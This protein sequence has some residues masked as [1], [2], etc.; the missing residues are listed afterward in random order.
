MYQRGKCWISDFWHE[1]RRY[2]KSWGA[3]SKTV[4]GEKDRKFRTEVLEGKHEARSRKITFKAF[5]GKYLESCRLNLKPKFAKRREVSVKALLPHFGNKLLKEISPFMAEQFKKT[6]RETVSPATVN[7]D[8][9]CLKNTLS[10]A[11]EWG[12]LPFNSL[13][14]R[15]VR[16]F[17]EDNEKMWALSDDEEIKLLDAC[18]KSPQ[19]GAK[20]DKLFAKYLRDLV[21]VALHSGMREGEIFNLRKEKVFLRDR[22]IRV[23]D[24]KNGED[25][26]VPIND[27]LKAVL[28]NRMQDQR[29]EYLFCNSKRERLTVLSSAFWFAIREAGLTRI[30]AKTGKEVRFRFHDLRHTFGSRL[31]MAGKDLKTIM[32]IMGHKSTRVA[33]RY[34]HPAPE[35]KLEAVRSLDKTRVEVPPKVP[36]PQKDEPKVVNVLR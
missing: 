30:D 22:Y 1:G 28:E 32:E 4:A 20:R 21:T 7:R 18:E 13:A 5:S 10:K 26:S 11:V 36:L 23:T 9:D 34:Q 8:I 29:S 17:K 25:R 3:I 6:R 35:H 2:K 14:G 12:Y 16:K 24:T 15:K 27:T 33:M 31:G 19:R